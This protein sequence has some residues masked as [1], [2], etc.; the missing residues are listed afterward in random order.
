MSARLSFSPNSLHIYNKFLI[1]F[2]KNKVSIPA[3]LHKIGK[4]ASPL[5]VY[6]LLSI[7]LYYVVKC[8]LTSAYHGKMPDQMSFLDCITFILDR[9]VLCLIQSCYPIYANACI[10]I[11]EFPFQKPNPILMIQCRLY[12]R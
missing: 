8:T 2:L 11:N 1:V 7:S 6:G 5:C 9:L 10:G 3:Y 4:S 12:L